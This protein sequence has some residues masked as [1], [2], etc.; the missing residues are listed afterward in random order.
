ML[1]AES[2]PSSIA[3]A[4]G[5]PSLTDYLTGWG[6]IALALVTVITV[7]VALQTAKTDRRRDDKRRDEIEERARKEKYAR[8]LAQARLVITDIPEI[9]TALPIG[10]NLNQYKVQFPFVNYGD[11]PVI[12]IE[13]EVWLKDD[14]LD[15]PCSAR[16]K[17]RYLLVKTPQMFEVV[18]NSSASELRLAAWRIRWTDADGYTWCVDQPQ[19]PEPLLYEGGPPRPC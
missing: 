8:Q 19:Q 6:T 9:S 1:P 18:I 17:E 14:P 12:E 5:G 2:I 16:K 13:A 11:R 10:K 4:S 15:N 3:S 7:L